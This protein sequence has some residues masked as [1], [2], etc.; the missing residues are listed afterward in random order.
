MNN[1]HF[2]RSVYKL[3]L[4]LFA[5]RS[6]HFEYHLFADPQCTHTHTHFFSLRICNA[7]FDSPPQTAD[8]SFPLCLYF[9]VWCDVVCVRDSMGPKRCPTA[10]ASTFSRIQQLRQKQNEQN[11]KHNSAQYAQRKRRMEQTSPHVNNCLKKIY[12]N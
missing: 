4:N 10:R 6:K 3:Y 5:K 12:R 8:A 2:L 7:F 1:I 11:T 9:L